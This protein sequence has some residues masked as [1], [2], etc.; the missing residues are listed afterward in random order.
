[1]ED[2]NLEKRFKIQGSSQSEGSFTEDLTEDSLS[3]IRQTNTQTERQI[4]RQTERLTKGQKDRQAEEYTDK[5]TDT[6]RTDR[7]DGSGQTGQDSLTV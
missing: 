7:T 2:L 6:S 3:K 1:M 4:G 5:R